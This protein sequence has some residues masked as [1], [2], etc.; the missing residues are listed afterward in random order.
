MYQSS[1]WSRNPTPSSPNRLAQISLTLLRISLGIIFLWF[2]ALKFF[3]AMSPAEELATRTI[4]TLTLGIVEPSLS[5][6]VL[7]LWEVA[8]GLGLISNRFLRVTLVLLLVQMLGTFTPLLLFPQET[9]VQF[10]IAPSMEGQYILK[11]IVLISGALVIGAVALG[12]WTGA[13]PASRTR[14]EQ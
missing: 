10:P 1:V 13:T 5:R 4:Q 11:N 14:Q 6:P 3:P 8:I 7:A 2:G 12:G 9:W